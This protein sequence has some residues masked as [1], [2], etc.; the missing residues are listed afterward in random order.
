M[1]KLGQIKMRMRSVLVLVG[2][3]LLFSL[4]VRSQD[5]DI[6]KKLFQD[7][8][9]AMGGEAYLNV[10]DM[11]SEGQFFQFNSQGENSGLIKFVD[12]TKLPDK[13]RH[14]SGNKKRDLDISVFNLEKNEG[15]I[16]EGQ[17]DTREAKPEEMRSFRSVVKHSIDTIFHY[18]Y[19]D[20]ENK[21]FYMGPGEGK[22]VTLELVKIVDPENDETTVY[23]DRIS[24]LPARIEYRDINNRGIRVR[25]VDEFSQWHVIQ[26]VNTPMRV[27][28]SLNGRRASQTFVLKISY[29]TNIPDSFFSKPLPPKK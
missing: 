14:E 25:L 3:V 26:G 13:S 5:E 8:I 4:N 12:Y 24:K 15:W 20:P 11:T 29:N 22:D 6:I 21:L 2:F 28:G 1:T 19:K 23:F 10:K 27:D 16:Q 17:K 18:R 9:E 7:A